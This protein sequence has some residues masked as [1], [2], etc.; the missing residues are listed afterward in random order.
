MTYAEKITY[1]SGLSA[2]MRTLPLND[3]SYIATPNGGDY[4]FF[5]NDGEVGATAAVYDPTYNAIKMTLPTNSDSGAAGQIYANFSA[6]RDVAFG[7]GS[8]LQVQFQQKFNRVM[9][10]PFVTVS[11]PGNDEGFKHM[12]MSVGDPPI[13]CTTGST[14]T[15]STSNSYNQSVVLQNVNAGGFPRGYFYIDTGSPLQTMEDGTTF[16]GDITWQNQ[17][18]SPFCLYSQGIGHPNETDPPY[19]GCMLYRTGFATPTGAD[20][21][22]SKWATIT[23]KMNIGSYSAG[24]PPV[25]TSTRFRLWWAWEGESAQFLHDFTADFGALVQAGWGKIWLLPYVTGKSNAAAHST[26]YAWYKNLII[27]NENADIPLTTDEPT[28][29]PRRIVAGMS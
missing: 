10:G 19:A 1:L 11:G 6:A 25:F 21:D 27:A 17:R 12:I 7:A 14:G 24:P 9:S 26:A 13:T 8:T 2:L 20:S 15:C 28:G 23:Y 4:G 22:I 29:T 16:P 5:I 18:P 3:A